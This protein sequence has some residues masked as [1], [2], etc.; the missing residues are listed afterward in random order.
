MKSITLNAARLGPRLLLSILTLTLCLS[1]PAFAASDDIMPAMTSGNTKDYAAT[2][3]EETHPPIRISPD[4]T[5]MVRLDEDAASII[6]SNPAHANVMMDSPRLLLLAPRQPG[7]TQ[8][9]VLNAEGKVIMQRH[10]IVVG[11]EKSYVRVRRA[12]ING[13]SSCEPTTVYYC[14]SGICHDV[15]LLAGQGNNTNMV[16]SVSAG[17]GPAETS[18]E[19]PDPDAADAE[20]EEDEE[21]NDSPILTNEQENELEEQQQGGP[22]GSTGR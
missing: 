8:F 21:D 5:E 18:G 2:S 17:S 11:P 4:K 14:P 1:L 22:S 9:T 3:G 20:L 12:C 7:A 13:N 16:S 19:I 15:E 10:I 6:V